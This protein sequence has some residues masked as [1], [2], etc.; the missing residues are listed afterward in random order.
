MAGEEG[1]KMPRRRGVRTTKSDATLGFPEEVPQQHGPKA[2]MES[3]AN[4]RPS[5]RMQDRIR[6]SLQNSETRP[7]KH[8]VEQAVADVLTG[9]AGRSQEQRLIRRIAA[10]MTQRQDAMAYLSMVS[11]VL[12]VMIN[13][14][15]AQS[16]YRSAAMN[17]AEEAAFLARIE[18]G[19]SCN[20]SAETLMKVLQTLLTAVLTGLIVQQY[21]LG[22]RLKS[23]SLREYLMAGDKEQNQQARSEYRPTW[24]EKIG[25]V[26][27]LLL[28][29]MHTPPYLA[30]DYSTEMLGKTIYYRAE[31]ILCG[32]ML[33][34]LVH[35]WRAISLKVNFHYFNLEQSYLLRDSKTIHLL[36]VCLRTSLAV[37]MFIACAMR[38]LALFLCAGYCCYGCVARQAALCQSHSC[39]PAYVAH[40]QMSN[41]NT[42]FLSLKLAIKRHP[43]WMLGTL[44]L[45][46]N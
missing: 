10:M 7:S 2:L 29:S 22:I 46:V 26:L 42:S 43:G 5:K 25:V 37:C 8:E 18:E 19:R 20:G 44:I 30:Y 15:C 33:L 11:I 4:I 32:L 21:R 40:L 6:L 28:S 45:V 1:V 41:V 35:V 31:S 13:E 34:R 17:V 12:A 16:D 27:D 39:R 24:R 36:R 38:G 23:V 3:S 14:M 9:A